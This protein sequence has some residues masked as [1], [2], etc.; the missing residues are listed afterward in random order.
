MPGEGNPALDP[1]EGWLIPLPAESREFLSALTTDQ[2][3]AWEVP[4]T[5]V[6]VVAE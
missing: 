3:G 6:G 5:N 1:D 4:G 2:P